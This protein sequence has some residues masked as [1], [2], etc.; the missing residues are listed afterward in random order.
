MPRKIFWKNLAGTIYVPVAQ[1]TAFKKCCL[2][3]GKFDG[4]N[5]EYFFQRI[6]RNGTRRTG[7]FLLLASAGTPYMG[8]LK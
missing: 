6:S 8:L 4:S 2:P 3:S 1:D 5:R 7:G